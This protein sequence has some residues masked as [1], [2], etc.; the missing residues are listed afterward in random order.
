[1]A[2]KSTILRAN[3]TVSD[4]DRG[5]FAEH[6][7]TLARHPSENDERMMA[8]VLAFELYASEALQFGKGLSDVAQADLLEPDL[9]GA[10]TRWIEVG[11]PDERAIL[12][13]C[14]RAAQM[15]V[16]AYSSSANLWWSSI[17]AK[18]ERAR[19]LTVLAIPAAQTQ[20]LAAMA[21]RNMQLQCTIQDA[22]VWFNDGHG[23]VQID[24]AIWLAEQKK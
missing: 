20:A 6:I 24:P 17:K 22:Q 15:V 12:K 2:L 16:I 3:L 14:G 11:Q 21:Q 5:H 7:L 23:T 4:L 13:A 9:T 19:N 18:L 10:L 1:M 8:R